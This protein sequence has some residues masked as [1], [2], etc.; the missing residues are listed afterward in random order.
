ML[1]AS[2]AISL[3]LNFYNLQLATTMY[4]N[5]IVAT[6]TCS[7]QCTGASL[8]RIFKSDRKSEQHLM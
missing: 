3:T 6:Y 7:W 5:T 1:S 8:H 2:I 4:T